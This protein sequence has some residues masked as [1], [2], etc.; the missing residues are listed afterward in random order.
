VP[1]SNKLILNTKPVNLQDA[2]SLID[3]IDVLPARI[4]EGIKP[5]Q[6]KQSSIA[7]TVSVFQQF[8][9][10]ANASAPYRTARESSC[11]PTMRRG[12]SR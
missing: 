10:N 5:I 6:A 8:V 9:A 3:E 4:P 11:S 12:G 2:L 1:G 7:K